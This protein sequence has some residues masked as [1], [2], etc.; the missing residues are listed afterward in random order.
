MRGRA[1][2]ISA[3]NLFTGA[4]VCPAEMSGQVTSYTKSNWVE[5]SSL[6][7]PPVSYSP[8]C[9]SR[10]CISFC[11]VLR[12]CAIFKPPICSP[13][14]TKPGSS[15]IGPPLCFVFAQFQCAD[16]VR[17]LRNS[18]GGEQRGVWSTLSYGLGVSSALSGRYCVSYPTTLCENA[19]G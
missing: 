13:G 4:P 1:V 6:L 2:Q 18:V 14:L 9:S 10:R 3:P 15:N 11:A 17:K 19:L 8:S 5:V 7:P 12:N 16:K